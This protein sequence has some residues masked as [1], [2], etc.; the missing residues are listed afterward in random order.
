M[1]SARLQ[2]RD[3][4]ATVRAA[5]AIRFVEIHPAADADHLNTEWVVL[6]NDGK[7]PFQTRGCGMTVSVRGTTKRSQLGIIDPG[8]VLGPGDRMR[9]LT[10]SPGKDADP[11][12]DEAGIKNY[13]LLLP[14]PYLRGAGTVLTLT[15]RGM[16]ICKAEHDPAAEAGLAVK[17]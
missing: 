4:T 12:P 16:P 2:R 17:G 14:R 6:E 15:L 1:L 5:M 11:P 10:G 9:M 13:Y 8:F 3:A 7:A